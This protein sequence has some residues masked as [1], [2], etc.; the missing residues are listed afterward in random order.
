MGRRVASEIGAGSHR[1]K[2][3]LTR[4]HQEERDGSPSNFT[5]LVKEMKP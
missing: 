5:L 3:A 4:G 1:G 2:A